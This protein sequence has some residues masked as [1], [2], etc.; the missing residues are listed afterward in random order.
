MFLLNFIVFDDRVVDI[1]KRLTVKYFDFSL[2]QNS[3]Y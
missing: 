1:K 3:L 2:L